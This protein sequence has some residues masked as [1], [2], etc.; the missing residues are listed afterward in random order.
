VQA[1]TYDEA[2]RRVADQLRAEFTDP[3]LTEPPGT[4]RT[5]R[6]AEGMTELD[7]QGEALVERLRE[8]LAGI[9]ATLGT[10][11]EEPPVEAIKTVLNGSEFV[12]RG[13]LAA[14]NAKDVLRLLPSFVFLVAVLVADQDRAI[15]L[16]RRT[17]EMTE[18]FGI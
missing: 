13:K 3:D 12:I 7:P 6:E 2:L 14:G 5:P 10:G 9:A 18:R 15:E 11:Q 8:V 17:A 1:G 16:S 4:G